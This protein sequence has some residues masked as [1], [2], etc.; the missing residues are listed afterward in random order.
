MQSSTLNAA[1]V[2]SKAIDGDFSLNSLSLTQDGT[3]Q[4]LAVQVPARSQIGF[5]RV[6]PRP[7]LDAFNLANPHSF[8]VWIGESATEPKAA[9]A[10]YCGG[11][12]TAADAD[13]AKPYMVW[14]LPRSG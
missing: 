4:W 6:H 8:E 13:R 1:S 12:Y 10:Y 14:W 9:G 7:K 2:A 3:E 11:P 5:V